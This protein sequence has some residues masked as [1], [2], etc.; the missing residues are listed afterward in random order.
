MRSKHLLAYGVALLAVSLCVL[1]ARSEMQ[2]RRYY[3]STTFSWWPT[4]KDASLFETFVRE[5]KRKGMNSISLDIPWTIQRETGECDFSQFDNRVDYAV[6]KGMSVFILVNTTALG[7]NSPKWLTDDMLQCTPDGKVYRRETDGG[8]LP[9][10]AH[11]VVRERI[12]RFSK[13]VAQHYGMRYRTTLAGDYPVV[14]LLPAFDLYMQTE[15]FPD[16]D[17][18]YSA[19][20]QSDFATWVRTKYTSIADLNSKWGRNLSGWQDVTLKDAH[21]TARNLYFEFTLQRVL[22]AI[23]SAVHKVSSLQVGLQAGSIWDNPHRRTMNVTPLLRNLDWLLV[24]DLPD[25]DHAFSADYARCSAPGKKTASQVEPASHAQAAN[26][27]YF[28]Q[29]VRAFEHGTNAVFLANW[30][31][32]NIKD[33]QKWPFLHFVGK[34]T[35]KPTAYPTP[36]QAIY[37]STWDLINRVTTTGQYLSTYEA[38]S[39]SGKRP[40]DVLSDY[41]IARNPERL[42]N[43]SEIYLPANWTIPPDVRAALNRVQN[44]LK[45]AKPLIAGTIDEYGRPVEAFA[46]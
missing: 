23:G 36:A 18:D 8:A 17:V 16:A 3:V 4:F 32:A 9:S 27:R 21:E 28:N 19:A 30:D 33:N 25:Y 31:I 41:V 43:Y 2:D 6:S 1:P 42:S 38:L 39:E 44:K 35:R 24:T 7:G 10:L 22:D 46:K 34:L 11:P 12:V 37:V 13:A 5:S 45:I 40:I 15:Y 14:A 26:T 20:A 29:G